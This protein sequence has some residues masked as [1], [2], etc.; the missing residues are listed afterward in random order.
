MKDYPVICLLLNTTLGRVILG[1]V[2]VYI[3]VYAM[4]FWLIPIIALLIGVA[5][6]YAYKKYPRYNKNKERIKSD[7]V[8]GICLVVFALLFSLFL[9]FHVYRKPLLH[10]FKDNREPYRTEE[11]VDTSKW[12]PDT[13]AM[14]D[15]EKTEPKKSISHPSSSSRSYESSDDDNMRGFDPASEDDMDDNGMSRYMENNDEEGWE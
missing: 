12:E 9:M 14:P 8:I 13:I 15:T 3:I 6:L 5:T 2:V 1:I 10:Y 4:G 7:L 11:I